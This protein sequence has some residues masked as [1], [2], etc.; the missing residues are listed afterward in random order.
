[1]KIESKAK[2]LVVIAAILLVFSSDDT[3]HA[4]VTVVDGATFP[5]TL[6][7]KQTSFQL[8]GAALLRYLVFIKAYAG[9]LYLPESF[10]GSQALDDIP[11]HLVLEYRVSIASK[12]FGEATITKIKDSVD[13]DVFE[14]LLPRI[15]LLNQLYRDVEPG[16]RYSLTY[17]PGMGT[18]LIY[19]SSP[20]GT[21]EGADFAKALFAVWIGD[22]PIDT[23]FRDRLLGKL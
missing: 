2:N 16:D 9:A 7:T 17:I 1:M 22:N 15:E 4:S 20:L 6:E 12:D 13:G 23:E 10:S 5:I 18:Q 11:K 19:N 14:R 3:I 8:K 21:I